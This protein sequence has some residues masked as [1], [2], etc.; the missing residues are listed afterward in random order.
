MDMGA[1]LSAVDDIIETTGGDGNVATET[2]FLNSKVFAEGI[3]NLQNNSL[4]IHTVDL[5]VSLA[6]FERW[7]EVTIHQ[8]LGVKIVSI[9]QLDPYCFHILVDSGKARAHIFANSPLKMGTKMVFPLPWDT[10]FSTRDLKSRAVPVWLELNNVHPGLMT[11]GLNMLRKIGPIIYAAKNVETQ[12]VNIIRGC[13][14]MD[15]SK[16]LPEFIP[17][18]VPE[19]PEKLMKQRIK[20]LR[21]PD[22]CFQCRQRGH[23]ARVCPLNQNRDLHTGMASGGQQPRRSSPAMPG[24]AVG[25]VPEATGVQQGEELQKG[26]GQ[27]TAGAQDEFRTVRRKG[28][29]RFQT[30]EIKKSMR[31]DNRYGILEEPEEI[32]QAEIPTMEEEPWEIRTKV[33]KSQN[34][35]QR[36]TRGADLASSSSGPG[37]NGGSSWRE[38]NVVIREVVDLTKLKETKSAGENNTAKIVGSKHQQEDRDR[39]LSSA[40]TTTPMDSDGRKKPRNAG[41]DGSEATRGGVTSAHQHPSGGRSPAGASQV[42]I[43]HAGAKN[44]GV[45][46]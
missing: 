45:G 13:V 16:P 8:L 22:A 17:I 11:F 39:R 19:A 26:D 12:R 43:Q 7:A 27:N 23:F 44:P 29:P 15:L 42:Q 37:L 2:L 46:A 5:R 38:L 35:P 6:Y 4:V 21:L 9:C 28:K 33:A 14:L 10:K 3:R 1:L 36:K 25:N 31:V 18:A 41:G 34:I 24:H 20:Y 30:P 40:G 32:P